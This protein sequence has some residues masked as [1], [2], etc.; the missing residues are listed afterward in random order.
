MKCCD[1]NVDYVLDFKSFKHDVDCDLCD[2][3]G[4]VYLSDGVSVTCDCLYGYGKKYRF[5]LCS[6]CGSK[7][8][9]VT[10][11]VTTR[12]IRADLRL[13]LIKKDEA[14]IERLESLFCGSMS[15]DNRCAWHIDHIKPIKYFLDKGITDYD[16]INN[17]M[18]LQPLWAEENLKKGA[19][20]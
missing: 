15:W 10:R 7:I 1:K 17:P 11:K 12:R 5:S 9:D 8:E 6:I 14:L 16:T 20:Y 3:N 2:S 13:K 18:N 4:D 19:K